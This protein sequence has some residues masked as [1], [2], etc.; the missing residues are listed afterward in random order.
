MAE[1]N[2]FNLLNI[3]IFFSVLVIIGLSVFVGTFLFKNFRNQISANETLIFYGT[4]EGR[5]ESEVMF[6]KVEPPTQTEFTTLMTKNNLN[7]PTVYFFE[8]NNVTIPLTI[9]KFLPGISD[10]FQIYGYPNK[11]GDSFSVTRIEQLKLL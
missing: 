3:I 11:A 5:T 2:K 9:F 7:D 4:V 10:T 8:K 1:T 6:T